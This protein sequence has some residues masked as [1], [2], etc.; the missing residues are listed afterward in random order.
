MNIEQ[1]KRKKETLLKDLKMSETTCD[2]WIEMT[3]TWVSPTGIYFPIGYQYMYDSIITKH[4]E[5]HFCEA[6]CEMIIEHFRVCK[7]DEWYDIPK[8][9]AVAISINN[10]RPND[11]ADG[12]GWR[13]KYR[14]DKSDWM[15]EAE[16]FG[17]FPKR[18]GKAVDLRK[19]NQ[20]IGNDKLSKL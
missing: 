10:L 18:K 16:K 2:K 9:V 11:E 6:G 20:I 7:D 5:Y 3:A 12:L 8:D 17:A 13:K 14:T 4:R 15:T 1:K 19:Y